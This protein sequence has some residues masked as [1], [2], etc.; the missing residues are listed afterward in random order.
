MGLTTNIWIQPS[1]GNTPCFC[2]VCYPWRM[3]TFSMSSTF[4]S[5]IFLP[6]PSLILF[7][8]SACLKR[9]STGCRAQFY[10][11]IFH[12]LLRETFPTRL[13]A[14]WG[15]QLHLLITNNNG[16]TV[17]KKRMHF[18]EVKPRWVRM[19]AFIHVWAEWRWRTYL[20]SLNLTDLYSQG[21]YKDYYKIIIKV[22]WDNACK[23]K[24]CTANTQ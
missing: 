10:S 15:E 9:A 18:K 4:S 13:W 17:Q 11:S 5:G 22:H 12:T 2:T 3:R 8:I 24:L 21:Y 20:I 14:P 6:E 16:N 7:Q 19:S 1:R 23:C